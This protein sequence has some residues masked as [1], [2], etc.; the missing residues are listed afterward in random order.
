MQANEIE[1]PSKERRNE[2]HED[3]QDLARLLIPRWLEFEPDQVETHLDR[4][5]KVVH[6]WRAVDC[7]MG[8]Q[9]RIEVRPGAVDCTQVCFIEIADR[10]GAYLCIV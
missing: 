10:I 4:C 1:N 3:I 5:E 7:E 2:T 6:L 9:R 8:C